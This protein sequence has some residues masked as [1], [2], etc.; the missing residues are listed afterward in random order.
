MNVFLFRHGFTLIS[1]ERNVRL[2]LTDH[3]DDGI[4]CEH[5]ENGELSD[6]TVWA[7]LDFFQFAYAVRGRSLKALIA[8]HEDEE[9]S[10]FID[11]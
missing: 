5:Y 4:L 9:E 6:D 2:S 1:D 11:E 7:R 10:I 8:E 3:G